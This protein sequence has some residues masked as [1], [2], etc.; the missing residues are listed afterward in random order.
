MGQTIPIIVTGRYS[1]INLDKTTFI[2][3]LVLDE[4]CI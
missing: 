4:N 1:H 2:A 3:I